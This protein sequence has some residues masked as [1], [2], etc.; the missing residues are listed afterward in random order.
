MVIMPTPLASIPSSLE[1]KVELSM[2]LIVIA[3]VPSC[4]TSIPSSPALKVQLLM[5]LISTA[6]VL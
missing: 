4:Q 5:P 6:P 1:L 3:P 2:S